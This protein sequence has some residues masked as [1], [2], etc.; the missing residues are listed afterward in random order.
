MSACLPSPPH[1]LILTRTN[2]LARGNGKFWQL[3]TPTI[4]V[5]KLLSSRLVVAHLMASWVYS[6]R[7]NTSY[8]LGWKVTTVCSTDSIW[9]CHRKPFTCET[10]SSAQSQV[11]LNLFTTSLYFGFSSQ[12]YSGSL[13]CDTKRL[14]YT[15]SN[16]LSPKCTQTAVW[17]IDP[18]SSCFVKSSMETQ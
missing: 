12:V 18:A 2:K 13:F 4:K 16:N 8:L 14:Y 10:H 17:N 1:R 15:R 7:W 6:W 11:P 5:C 9:Q 3:P